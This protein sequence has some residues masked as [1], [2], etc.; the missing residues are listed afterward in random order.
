MF[1]E[2]FSRAA[3]TITKMSD[4]DMFLSQKDIRPSTVIEGPSTQPLPSE[5]EYH[6]AVLFNFD[7][8]NIEPFNMFLRSTFKESEI[9]SR[10]FDYKL[11][12]DVRLKKTY[13]P[14]LNGE[15]SFFCKVEKGKPTFCI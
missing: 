8:G 2:E 10:W 11:A 12:D 6:W 3:N 4:E 9:P 14:T 5:V 15:Y 1:I 7:I 13:I